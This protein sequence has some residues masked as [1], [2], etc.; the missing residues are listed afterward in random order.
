VSLP[1]KITKALDD[2]QGETSKA[3]DGLVDEVNQA[4][5]DLREELGD[6]RRV[7]TQKRAP[8][9][10]RRSTPLDHVLRNTR[11]GDFKSKLEQFAVDAW[12]APRR[13]TEARTWCEPINTDEV[14]GTHK[15]ICT[16]E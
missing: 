10:T 8:S 7:V 4:L 5:A 13:F 9:M 1:R 11:L 14:F 3:L 12:R 6:V 15:G 2:L 16:G